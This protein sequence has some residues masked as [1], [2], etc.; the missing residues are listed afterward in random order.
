[1]TAAGWDHLAA[2]MNCGESLIGRPAGCASINRINWKRVPTARKSP[3]NA[4]ELFRASFELKTSIPARISRRIAPPLPGIRERNG[5][6]VRDK[7]S[8]FLTEKSQIRSADLPGRVKHAISF[9]KADWMPS[10]RKDRR[11]PS[12]N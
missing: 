5:S 9:P 10:L 7:I 6:I 1:M 4:A 8:R 11:A 2:E 3:T 12:R